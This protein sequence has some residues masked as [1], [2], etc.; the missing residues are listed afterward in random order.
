MKKTLE[1]LEKKLNDY[2]KMLEG[3]LKDLEP[4]HKE[5]PEIPDHGEIDREDKM[6]TD[7][8][9]NG[10]NVQQYGYDQ[11]KVV[12]ER[13]PKSVA[14][15][16]KDD[17]DEKIKA[18][19]KAEMDKR[20]FGE[21]DATRHI[22]DRDR[23]DKEA[24][25]PKPKPLLQTEQEMVKYDSN[26]QWKIEKS[27]YGP[28]GMG[29]YTDKDNIQRKMKNTGEE[30]KDAGKNVNAKKYTTSGSTMQAAHESAEAKRQA[31]KTKASTKIF[32]DEEKKALE[33][34]MR[35][36]GRLKKNEVE[37]SEFED[38]T[39]DVECGSDVD[40]R[41]FDYLCKSI[42]DE[43]FDE[44]EKKEWSPKAK[45]KSKKGGLTAA[46]RKSYNKATGGNLKAPQPGGGPRKRSFC[47]RNKGQID[48]HNI[49]CKK[50]PDKRAC[51][52]R[53]RWKC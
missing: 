37:V 13:V 25:K 5:V 41:V 32:S 23:G 12:H 34:K 30:F 29:Q 15:L 8:W 27:N 47:A 19:M 36:E 9:R 24:A 50:N 3:N 20:K 51:K 44:L 16:A 21:A 1:K 22:I 52:A 14:N 18:K 38:G 6:K 33:E 4:H 2:K 28:K 46:G 49:D 43:G 10:V 7:K 11:Q 42:M 35:Q 45:H 26:G 40:R 48:K 39:I 31:A 53:R 17:L